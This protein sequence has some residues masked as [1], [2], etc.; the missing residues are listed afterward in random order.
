MA[1]ACFPHLA[2]HFFSNEISTKTSKQQDGNRDDQYHG[3]V[4]AAI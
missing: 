2:V 3:D 4:F 1:A